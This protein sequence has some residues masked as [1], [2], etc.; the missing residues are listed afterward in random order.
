MI[1]V[2][3]K[4]LNKQINHNIPSALVPYYPSVLNT[5]SAEAY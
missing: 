3:N 2:T 5:K 4:E 1:T